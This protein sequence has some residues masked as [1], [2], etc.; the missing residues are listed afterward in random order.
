MDDYIGILPRFVEWQKVTKKEKKKEAFASLAPKGQG[1]WQWLS[2]SIAAKTA[3]R[4]TIGEGRASE[5]SI[6][7]I[8]RL[9]LAYNAEGINTKICVF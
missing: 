1:V 2:G 4:M 5:G 3:G 7:A 8:N 9:S 6:L